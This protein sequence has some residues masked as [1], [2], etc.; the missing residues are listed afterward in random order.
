MHDPHGFEC[1]T[2]LVGHH[3]GEGGLVA[4]TVGR[5]AGEDHQKAVGF[6]SSPG[7]LTRNVK[8]GLG[9]ELRWPWG[10]LD[11]HGDTDTEV[12]AIVAGP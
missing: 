11:E 3:L 12:P 9:R 5:L 8:A 4:L 10:V 2:E 1:H 6:E 7:S